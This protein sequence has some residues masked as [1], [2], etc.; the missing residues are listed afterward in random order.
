EV[1]LRRALF[2]AAQF[3]NASTLMRPP[4]QTAKGQAERSEVV[5]VKPLL[6]GCVETTEVDLRVPTGPFA[7]ELKI[8]GCVVKERLRAQPVLS[9]VEQVFFVHREFVLRSLQPMVTTYFAGGKPDRAFEVR[10]IGQFEVVHVNRNR[11][12]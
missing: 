2:E 8:Y 10:L 11:L 12:R 5:I 3:P 9:E 1:E 7:S 6:R 4:C